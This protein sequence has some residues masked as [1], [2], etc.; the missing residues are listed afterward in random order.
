MKTVYLSLGANESDRAGNIAKA[1][2]ELSTS[3]VRVVRKSSLYETEP[4]NALGGW[5]LNCAVEAETEA[6]PR[7]LMD[8]LL[9]IERSLGRD[10][11]T[12]SGV[13][14]AGPKDTRTID[15]DIL[16]FGS[17]VVR[18]PE[19][20]IPHP[21][22]ADRRFVLVPLAEIASEVRHPILRMTIAELLAETLDRSVV[23]P[24][25]APKD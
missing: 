11:R 20:E 12:N 3:G 19:L 22:M 2:Q 6:M 18:T 4:V 17:S 21:R 8:I 14:D 23:R 7:Q 5:F 25:A 15:L 16:L 24:F 13:N 9:R 1:I 10:R